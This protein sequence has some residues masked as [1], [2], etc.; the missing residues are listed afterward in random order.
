MTDQTQHAA[1]FKALHK[2]GNALVL[3]N[4]WDAGT[5]NAVVESG[6]AAVATASHAI[7][8]SHGYSDGQ[9]CPF[10]FSLGV[11][12]QIITAID[13]PVTHDIERGWGETPEEVA[14]SCQRVIKTGAVGLNIEDSLA[15]GSLR[16]VDDQSAR[17]RAARS[18]MDEVAANCFINARCD[19]LQIERASEKADQISSVL[20]R[21]ENYADAGATGLFIPFTDDL[22]LIEEICRKSPL[23]VNVMRMLDGHSIA[24]FNNAGVARISHGPFGYL[25]AMNAYKTVAKDIYR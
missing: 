25:A 24:D 6:A 2:P 8:A 15:D 11:L 7:A 5:A 14:R 20:T 23:P 10:E 17:I 9:Q 4:S 13:V 12:T 16:A 22:S 18:A 3:F 1:A 21:A 19:V